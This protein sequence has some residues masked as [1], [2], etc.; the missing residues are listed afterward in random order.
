VSAMVA[1]WTEDGETD[2]DLHQL[3]TPREL[4]DEAGNDSSAAETHRQSVGVVRHFLRVEVR[5]DENV[6]SQV[7]AKHVFRLQGG[8]GEGGADQCGKQGRRK[9]ERPT[10]GN[11]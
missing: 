11:L 10:A 3:V 5:H 8:R 4:H 9:G 2:A 6:G 7:G 1:S